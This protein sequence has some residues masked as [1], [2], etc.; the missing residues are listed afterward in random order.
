[1]LICRYLK[2]EERKE[3]Q[4]RDGRL[5]QSKKQKTMAIIYFLEWNYSLNTYK[6]SLLC[7]STNFKLQFLA[8]IQLLPLTEL[9]RLSLARH[10]AISSH[11]GSKHGQQANA[12]SCAAAPRVSPATHERHLAIG[13]DGIGDAPEARSARSRRGA[14]AQ[15]VQLGICM[16]ISICI[17]SELPLYE[18]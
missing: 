16:C 11:M 13:V 2:G 15:L 3:A 17:C 10:A 1:M 18:L 5:K 7:F 9:G 12:S 6:A 14:L 8:K 4:L